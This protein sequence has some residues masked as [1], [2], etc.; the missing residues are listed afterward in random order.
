MSLLRL[1]GYR[2]SVYTWA[3]RMALAEAS[4]AA[5][6][7]EADPFDASLAGSLRQHHPF[8]RVPVLWDGGFRL[9]ETGAILEYLLPCAADTKTAARARQVAG[10][11]DSY[12]YLPL[13]RQVYSHAVFR[14]ALGRAG[15]TGEIA[16]GLA[17]APAVLAALEEIAAEAL[18]LRGGECAAAECHL[19]PMLGY[20]TQASQG[21]DMLAQFPA[22]QRWFSGISRRDSY[23][24]TRP[25]PSAV[26]ARA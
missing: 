1:I 22:L 21:R 5:L 8:A 3:V 2:F 7:E 25:D 26:G 17:A 18:V 13:V 19:A 12:A 6:Y 15:D 11:V 14:P 10:I 24:R 20:F 23:C 9:Y 16:A 4:V